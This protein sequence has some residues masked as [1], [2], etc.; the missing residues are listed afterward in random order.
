MA[1]IN[2][3]KLKIPKNIISSFETSTKNSYSVKSYGN[4]SKRYELNKSSFQNVLPIINFSKNNS[5]YKLESNSIL[6]KFINNHTSKILQKL[7]IPQLEIKRKIILPTKLKSINRSSSLNDIFI[8]KN[9][10]YNLNLNPSSGL[11]I[12][13]KDKNNI[14]PIN[15]IE[16]KKKIDNKRILSKIKINKI[17][18]DKF[19]NIGDEISNIKNTTKENEESFLNEKDLNNMNIQYSNLISDIANTSNPNTPKN[20]DSKENKNKL[21]F[22]KNNHNKYSRLCRYEPKE[23]IYIKRR[24][25]NR[26]SYK[27]SNSFDFFQIYNSD[28]LYQSKVFEEQ[29]KL[30]KDKLKEYKSI[31]LKNNFTE[32]IKST[33]LDM[34]IKYNKNIEEICGIL[35]ILP[36]ILLGEFYNLMLN[37]IK[38]E[39]PNED[40]FLPKFIKDEIENLVNNNKLLVEVNKYFNKCFD[41]YLIISRENGGKNN[42]LKEKEYFEALNYLEK[43]RFNILYLN[44]SFYNAE[45][46]YIEDL[47][48]INKIIKNKV[49]IKNNII[50]MNNKE[51][52]NNEIYENV[53]EEE[54][55]KKAL[56]KN[57]S[58]IEKIEN[59][60][61]FRRGLVD[62][63][64]FR[65]ESALGIIKQKRPLYNYLGKIIKNEK[66]LEYKS[67][68]DNKYFDKILPHCFKNVKD[69]IITQKINNEEKYGKI[70]NEY[71]VLK[72]NLG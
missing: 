62:E 19:N 38:I 40:K 35:Y 43:A 59:Q 2:P 49:I 66:K 4:K 8:K 54:E 45:N 22:N 34:K 6:T 10:I 41:F 47:S 71:K 68:F 26:P 30:F 11:F 65:I 61:M 9:D 33:S 12:T 69:K 13:E 32:V 67:I 15:Y 37:L 23:I 56:K 27:K 3:G 25:E 36:R 31:I 14:N 1:S 39:I 16:N 64:K 55:K 21:I 42:Y 5:K 18:L 72:I 58:V 51:D 60:F 53:K 44:N 29:V 57:F 50:N 46:N 48:T 52:L 70:G 7:I 24:N 63:K 20:S 17:N 28:T